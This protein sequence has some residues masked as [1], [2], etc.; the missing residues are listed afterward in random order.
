MTGPGNEDGGQRHRDWRRR[1]VL[2]LL[3][4]MGLAS[5]GA[6]CGGGGN[7]E[8]P[9]IRDVPTDDV[10]P[11]V[12]PPPP[13]PGPF[14]E[15]EPA[16][17]DLPMVSLVRRPTVAESVRTAVEMIG[18]MGFIAAGERVL[19]KPNVN[20]GLPYPATT[21]PEV[22]AEVARLALAAG[23]GEVIVG[24]RSHFADD[25]MK[26]LQDSGIAAAALAAGAR[27]VD[28]ETDGWTVVTPM[29]AISWPSGFAVSTLGLA[30]DH[31]ISL[32]VVKTHVASVFTL[33]MKNQVGMLRP[34][35]RLSGLHS[36]G[37]DQ[38]N[39]RIAEINLAIAPS[40]IVLD[41]TRAFV[42]GGPNTGL[43]RDVG[44]VIASGDRVSCDVTGLALLKSLGTRAEIAYR[45]VF[46]QSVIVRAISLNLGITGPEGYTALAE[47][48]PELDTLLGY[49][50]R[51]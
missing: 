45:H 9:E 16:P 24:D 5:L 27:V 14:P 28:L 1:E 3:G 6:G 42:S 32:P 2:E 29:E 7:S 47:G 23:A 40:L 33:S 26:N 34:D 30:V 12:A 13:L 4:A 51:S 44:M 41:A 17:G 43:V 48:V 10:A 19:I 35:D 36:G 20:S 18:G 15:F 49:I 38:K 39:A 46:D 37:G 22:V 25:S 11:I 31:V 8:T 21:N 50:A